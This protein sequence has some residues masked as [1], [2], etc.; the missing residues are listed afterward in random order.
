MTQDNKTGDGTGEQT[1]FNPPSISLPK[2]GG[3]IR[4]MGE[5]FAANPATG[6]GS[7]TVPIAATPGR[8]GFGPQLSLAYDSG[9]GNGPF[10][11]GWN[12]A[13]PAITRK[14]DKGLPK[15]EDERESDTFILSGAEDLVPVLSKQGEK[16]GPEILPNRTIE[17]DA[18]HIFQVKRYRP[19]TEGLFARIERWT[20]TLTNETHWRSISK[21]NITTVYGRTRESRIEDP[22]A[23]K[24]Q[25]RVFSWLICESHDDKGN[26]IYYEYEKENTNEPDLSKTNEK[27]RN[28][29]ANRYLKR[30]KYGNKTPVEQHSTLP[31]EFRENLAKRSDWLFELVLDYGEE[32]YNEIETNQ[33]EHRFV[34]AYNQKINGKQHR[35]KREDPFSSYRSGFEVRTCRL[36]HRVL[37][38]HHFPGEL[39]KTDYLV[40]STGFKYQESPIA[41]FIRSVTQSGYV[42]QPAEGFP[43]RYLEKSLPPL[44]FEYSEA[45]LRDKV[46][47][48][49]HQSIENM[50]QGLDGAAYQWA[51]IDGE[52]LSGILTEQGESWFFKE[53]LS[54]LPVIGEDG[55]PHTAARF[56]P[57]QQL[58]AIPSFSNLSGGRRQLLDL[59]GDGQLDVVT[60]DSPIPG[61]FERSKKEEGKEEGWQRFKRFEALPTIS[62][63]DPNLKFADLTGDGHADILITENETITW[64]QSLAERGFDQ[65]EKVGQALDEE[66]GPKL[67]FADG[68]ES[69]YLADFSGDGLTDLVRIR[70]GEICYWPNLGYGR[71]GGKVTMDNSPCMDAP[72]LF[73]QRRIRLADIDGSGVTDIIYLKNDG[74]YIYLNESGNGWAKARK[75][76]SFPPTDNL[77]AVTVADLLGNGT[78]CLVWSSPLPE[79]AR[80]PMRYIDLMGGQ[81]PHL[82]IKT[83]N[84][85]GAETH[86]HYAPSTKFQLADK[87]AG[88]PWMTKIPFPV[89]VVEKVETYDRISGNRF[90]TRYAYHHGYFDGVER[91]FRGFGMVE[92][93]DTETLDAL[94]KSRV[95]PT[96]GNMEKSAHVPPVLTKTWFH[97]GAFLDGKR[98]S[99]Q[100]AKEYYREG[101]TLG[102]PFASGGSP[103]G[104]PAGQG[105]APPGPPIST[106]LGELRCFGS[107]LPLHLSDI[108]LGLEDTVLPH[109]VLLPDGLREKWM[110]TVDEKRE[111]CRALKGSILR[112]EVY[113]LDG[114]EKADRP[115]TVSERNFTIQLLQPKGTNR[116]AVF[117]THER[118]TVNFHYERELFDMGGAKRADP[119]VSHS[120]ILDVDP[121]G[122]V[123]QS[124][125]IGYGRRYAEE[126]LEEADRLK[127]RQILATCMENDFT[128]GIDT[129]D[130]FRTPLPAETRT[131]E[132]TGLRLDGKVRFSIEDMKNEI[133]GA[134][135]IAYEETPPGGDL[136]TQKRLIEQERTLYRKNDLSGPLALGVLESRAFPY[137]SYELAFTPGLLQ[138]VYIDGPVDGHGLGAAGLSDLLAGSGG[139]VVSDTL[140]QEKLFP[141]SDGD[142]HWWI[143]SGQVFYAPEGERELAYAQERFFLPRR[144]QDPF[145]SVTTVDYDGCHLLVRQTTDPLGN[146]ETSKNNYRTLQPEMMT[147]PNGNRSAVAFDALGMVVGTAIMGKEAGRRE[148]DSLED[149]DAD[150]G[151][152]TIRDYV[153]NPLNNASTNPSN[154][155]GILKK[156]TTRLVYDLTRYRR[157]RSDKNPQ[158][159]VVCTLA[160]ETH[161]ADLD[162]D[163]GE[164]TRIR[165]TTIQHSFLYSD[166]FGREIQTKIQAEPGDAPLR[167]DNPGHRD[168]PGQLILV[169]GR[170][171][172]GHV[173][174]RWVGTGRTIYNNKGK[175]VKKYEPFFS[176][177]HL[178]EG[179]PEVAETGVTSIIFYDPLERAVA[180]LHPNHTYE[181]VVFD[182]WRQE[183]WD[184][185]DT[186]P[187][188]KI[189]SPSI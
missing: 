152:K 5:K 155:S 61:F 47:Y 16:W 185:N 116:H 137:N 45:T 158:P 86:I 112:Q 165:K 121:Y 9:A 117:F 175:P 138:R 65:G 130:V 14:T 106:A 129:D 127:Q 67:V 173:D 171:R 2:G 119:R 93:W 177:T 78:A 108:G 101:D 30:I 164:A 186:I 44:E 109:S 99:R 81:K 105:A 151:E 17:I 145:G 95:F 97:T 55:E 120:M 91:E 85:M 35:E 68:R 48:V 82:L 154:P 73:D 42:H 181:K 98:I 4:G 184:V 161:D 170:P 38:F 7:M 58:A 49:D 28:H 10:G 144:F 156:A 80:Q 71:F 160:R 143:P 21:D 51:D 176:A 53:N 89:H 22:K 84:N 75:P 15:Y 118:E 188:G 8:A 56:A 27:N 19:R 24:K 41:S 103:R 26:A 70:N 128:N 36:C 167:M 43:D 62:W 131:Y 37:V 69:V 182:P 64:Y 141:R 126:K 59:A 125:A 6:T 148:G 33:K 135:E 114:T 180:T 139:Y 111:A 54:P 60:F 57:I 23:P 169:N 12:L 153:C 74:V 76:D 142:G 31:R 157:T 147:D 39:D 32:H 136:Q 174:F 107:S 88:K 94:A 124:A 3:A 13:L 34:N 123:R 162:L 52:G 113:G 163:A 178:F 90:V 92:Q 122:N 46:E 25:P 110:M 72:D 66:N 18:K 50:P 132:M 183:T 104:L 83:V 172:I 168:R 11:F 96:G 134:V 29:S 159:N 146:V 77:S 189:R 1:H 150:L 20:N 63:Q 187:L 100:M 140:K 87:V 40:R 166:G 133:T 102:S 115:Y 79:H 179:E 149:F